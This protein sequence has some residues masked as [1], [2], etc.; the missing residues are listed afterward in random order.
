MVAVSP[1][2]SPAREQTTED[3]PQAVIRCAAST[4]ASRS[5][6]AHPTASSASHVSDSSAA[7]HMASAAHHASSPAACMPMGAGTLEEP[8]RSISTS[9]G[10]PP[11]AQ[12]SRLMIE[13]TEALIEKVLGPP[14][15]TGH[16]VAE[17]VQ[18][19]GTA[20][21]LVWTAAGG[22]VQYIEALCIDTGNEN[23][24]GTLTLTGEHMLTSCLPASFNRRVY[25]PHAAHAV[26]VLWVFQSLRRCL[27]RTVCFLSSAGQLGD[28]LEESA[29]IARSWVRAHAG[30]L[31]LDSSSAARQW[32]IHVH[33]P[34]GG[35]SCSC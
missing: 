31:G 11:T 28:V 18:L 14:P 2:P 33:L 19:A 8:V 25:Q 4:S 30:S 34:A 17:R 13:V 16:V 29:R 1:S 20:A 26:I 23:R 3:G 10:P 5:G 6:T 27:W 24:T 7:Q 22:K 12:H 32:D 35:L 15:Y 9:G 21:G